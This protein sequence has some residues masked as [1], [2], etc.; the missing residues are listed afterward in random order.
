MRYSQ[1]A[2]WTCIPLLTCGADATNSADNHSLQIAEAP[3]FSELWEVLGPFETG[4]RESSWGADPL[5]A[6]GGF[7]NLHYD[8]AASFASSLGLNGVVKWSTASTTA[9]NSTADSTETLLHINLPPHNW[10]FL[11]AVYGWDALQ[12]QAWA[13]GNLT[14][15]G[16]EN[17]T[18]ALYTDNIWE[19]RVDDQLYFGGDYF[20]FRRTP[21]LLNLAPGPHRIDLRVVR[22]VRAFGGVGEPYSNITLVAQLVPNKLNV[23]VNSILVADV[24]Q[25]RL[26][27]PYASVTLH[28]AIGNLVE[29]VGIK[30]VDQQAS[31]FD[32]Q[33]LRG[34]KFAGYQSRAVGFTIKALDVT[35]LP[36]TLSFYF[37]HKVD[38]DPM[39]RK[40]ENLT[41]DFNHRAISD[42]Q[43]ITFLHP[44]GVVSYATMR[45]PTSE[46]CNPNN[47]TMLP[48]L[49]GLHGAGQAANG[50]LVRTSFDGISDICAWTL[51]P[52]G[53]TP[54]SGDD[55]HTWG[56]ADVQNSV[57]ALKD[58]IKAMSWAGPRV[59]EEDWIVAGHSN[60]GHG[61]WHIISHYPDKVIAA[62]PVAGY[63]SIENYVPYSMW[64]NA[65]TLLAAVFLRARQDF[66]PE[67]LLDN[68]AG[69]PVYQQHSQA[70][71]NVVV[72]HS[73]LMHRL[74]EENGWP[75]KYHE[76][77]GMN[78]YYDGIMTSDYLK[79]FYHK[80]VK[81]PDANNI[82]P[83]NF[84][85]TIPPSGYVGSRGGIF[86]DQSHSPD[87]AGSVS[88]ERENGV[89]KLKTRNI[90]RFHLVLGAI[91]APVP[92]QI[93]IDGSEMFPVTGGN[94]TST[95]YT[96]DSSGT[97]TATQDS[98]WRSISE[99]YGQQTGV[100]AILRTAGPFT[101]V[102]SSPESEKIALQ[103]CRNLF[104]YLSADCEL[105]I[106]AYEGGSTTVYQTGNI[107]SIFLGQHLDKSRLAT[108][109]IFIDRD[110]LVIK[111]AQ[112]STRYPFEPGLGAIFLRPMGNERLE[113][114]IWGFD[115]AGLQQAARLVPI[116]TGVGQP[117]F[118]VVN[119]RTPL[120]GQGS[121]YAAGFFDSSWQVSAASYV[122]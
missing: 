12:Y 7:R 42:V 13:R 73:R 36:P 31:A 46:I 66:K 43:Q 107:I 26:V 62:A 28:N 30:A 8:P 94:S 50:E 22:D 21:L 23:D 49:L 121:L 82:L 38:G 103:T 20:A 69:I 86:V 98:S 65:D 118:V 63:T 27:S 74:M 60:G 108:F 75:S 81:R 33:L 85:I 109:P 97:W 101:V 114:V 117:D 78:H 56:F 4:T 16:T 57:L 80:Y 39:T 47:E 3:F 1:I 70:D 5:E 59:V 88:V 2:A 122:S 120:K 9:P 41:I 6:H 11:Q 100:N 84:S 64:H 91:R 104:Q 95:W 54:W 34:V 68:F 58:W 67:L 52:S 40:T 51:F 14:I 71:D 25:D 93:Q 61:T 17:V 15:P 87:R 111:T 44:G 55:W 24:V 89:W 18:V 113:L 105:S 83:T 106:A 110:A 99:R 115:M 37:E 53:V 48:V 72:Y 32:L 10:T 35:D 29:V 77:P 76:V 116:L 92:S 102:S 45:P 79:E 112:S 90:R 19:Y 119:K 96:Q